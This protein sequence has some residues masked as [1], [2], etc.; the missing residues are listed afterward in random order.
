MDEDSKNVSRRRALQ[1]LGLGGA[2]A[3]TIALPAKWTRPIVE[4]IVVPAHAAASNKATTTPQ[5]S[6]DIR[7][8]RDIVPVGKMDNGLT[9]YRFRYRWSETVYVG[10]MAQ[11]VLDVDPDAVITGEDGFY[12]VDYARLGT[13]MMTLKEWVAGRVDAIALADASRRPPASPEAQPAI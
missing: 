6:S 3:A 8:K 7:L 5:P 12:R 10:V 9:L 2:V 11:E 4:T 1:I 13:E